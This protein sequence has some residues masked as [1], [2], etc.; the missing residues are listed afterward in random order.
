M[1]NNKKR[2]LKMTLTSPNLGNTS[3]CRT[4]SIKASNKEK[5]VKEA[6]PKGILK[7]LMSLG[8][9][10][11]FIRMTNPIGKL[12]EAQTKHLRG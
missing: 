7:I 8:G 2:Y 1:Q 11:N 6:K 5:E 4:S 10:Q 12:N 9:Q 3:T